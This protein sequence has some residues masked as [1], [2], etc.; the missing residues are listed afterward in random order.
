[1]KTK[2]FSYDQLD[3]FIHRL[4]GASKLICFLIITSGVMFTYDYRVI[5][6]I[7]IFSWILVFFSKL[8]FKK[9]APLLLY[10]AIFLLFN[11][12]L[13]FLIT[14]Y[15]GCDVYGHKTIICHIFGNYDLTVEQIVYEGT[16]TLKY[17]SAI[18]LGFMMFLTTNPSEFASSL[19][20]IKV[21]YKA[22][23]ALSLTLRYFPDVSRDFNTISN[24]QQARGVDNSKKASLG[25]RI[26]NTSKI[27]IPLIFSTLDR[28]EAISNSMELRGYGKSNKR[29][30]YSFRPMKKEDYVSIVVAIL[31]L[32]ASLF[33]RFVIVKS[34][35]YFPNM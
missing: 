17:F 34:M 13:T 26:K 15:H 28:V 6:A 23:T 32:V 1:M 7:L 2:L 3:S 11:V 27:I 21:P 33:M 18:P 12:V 14:P 35:Y 9:M 24:A 25:K 31:I 5:I 22:C 30:W 19:N 4:S 29:T 20:N 16:K 10:V 8:S